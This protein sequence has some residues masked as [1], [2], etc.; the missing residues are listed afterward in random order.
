MN[1]VGAL[2][3]QKEQ[4]VERL[5]IKKGDTD[6]WERTMP[7]ASLH[8]G[9]AGTGTGAAETRGGTISRGLRAE[10]QPRGSSVLGR[11]SPLRQP[12]GGLALVRGVVR[13]QGG[14]GRAGVQLL[15]FA[16]PVDIPQL[17]ARARLWEISATGLLFLPP[18]VLWSAGDSEVPRGPWTV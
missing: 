8:R 17:S 4:H 7:G 5:R 2:P 9:A 6:S 13:G 12:T 18:R 10:R 11:P 15:W 3:G 1:R 14:L 16:P